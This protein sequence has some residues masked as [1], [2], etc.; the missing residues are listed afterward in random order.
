MRRTLLSLGKA[1]VVLESHGGKLVATS[2]AAVTAAS[3][4]GSVT[5]LV[6]SAALAAE[7][8]KVHGVSIVYVAKDAHVENGL[9]EELEGVVERI[10]KSEGITH[11]VATNSAFGKN[12]VPRVAAKFDAMPLTDVT[13]IVSEDTFVRSQYAGNAIT[14]VKTKGSVKFLTVRGTSFTRAEDGGSATAAD[15]PSAPAAGK[16]KWIADHVAKSDKPD[17]QTAPV[18]VSGGRGLKSGENFYKVLEPLAAPLKGALGA[19]RAVV[20]A[21]FVP[22]DLQIG[23]TGKVVAPNLYIAV[24][25]SGAIQHIAGMKDS[26]VIVAINN[27]PEANMFSIADYGLVADLFE[28]VPKLVTELTPK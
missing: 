4:L 14:T 22:N 26:K 18:V 24:G 3:K 20:D 6:Q 10:I 25:I 7:A 23:Q 11:V 21:G 19:T 1:L 5:A 9:P 2:K 8:Q 17:L 16:S 13:A 28:A 15:A 27:D 12:I